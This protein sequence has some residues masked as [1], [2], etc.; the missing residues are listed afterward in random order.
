MKRREEKKVNKFFLEFY[1]FMIFMQ[2]FRFKFDKVGK[3]VK[4]IKKYTGSLY[5]TFSMSNLIIL[6]ISLRSSYSFF[7]Q[8]L[9]LTRRCCKA[10]TQPHFIM[11]YESIS[12]V[13]ITNRHLLSWSQKRMLL[14][15]VN[16]TCV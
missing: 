14:I 2:M 10:N 12:T 6:T 1:E 16:V 7:K 13:S 15:D 3:K 11:N 9:N 8:H 5:S 4:F